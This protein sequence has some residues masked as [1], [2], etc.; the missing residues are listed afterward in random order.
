M[1]VN[2]HPL[3]AACLALSLLAQVLPAQGQNLIPENTADQYALGPTARGVPG[4]PHAFGR[5]YVQLEVVP[6]CSFDFGGIAQLVLIRCT[7]GV[8]YRTQ[9]LN[10]A[11]ATFGLTRVLAPRPQG[12]DRELM[13]ID[14]Q[15][16]DVEF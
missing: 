15:R 14:A 12:R 2:T 5:L 8:P 1:S 7:R 4:T 10:D 13:R 11:D 9:I 3:M 16:L 6:T